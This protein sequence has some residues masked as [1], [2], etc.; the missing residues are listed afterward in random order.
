MASTIQSLD[1]G[2]EILLIIGKSGKP[3][4]L[5]DISEHFSLDRSSVFR[6]IQTLMKKG[7]VV[8]ESETK[9][10]ALGF[11]VL[12]LS[13]Y[14]T[15]YGNIERLMRPILRRVATHTHQNTHLAILDGAEV[16]FIAVEQ[17]RDKI[18][19]NLSV[20]NRE[21]VAVTALGK[22]LMAFMEDDELRRFAG[23]IRFRRYTGSSVMTRAA[24]LEELGKVR[25]ER[26]AFDLEEYKKGIVC[27]AA[28]VMDH[29]RKIV[30]SMGISGPK[31]LIMPHLDEYGHAVRD[32]GIEASSLMGC[33]EP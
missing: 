32:A 24:L 2:L 19:L 27:V 12:E 25:E 13:G 23:T 9:R 15:E 10:Y 5:N 18:T 3:L 26:V 31:E 33:P 30:Y 21:P 22:A 29:R 20:G 7:F 14:F 16:V 17:P 11:R 28:P 6:L 4:S 1:R 8:Q